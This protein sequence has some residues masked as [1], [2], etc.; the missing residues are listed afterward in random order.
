MNGASMTNVTQYYDYCSG[1]DSGT[2]DCGPVEWVRIVIES[3]GA[4]NI[5]VG[6][7]GALNNLPKIAWRLSY[8]SRF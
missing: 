8:A 4:V 5:A 3:W 2:A 7:W 1:V 6:T